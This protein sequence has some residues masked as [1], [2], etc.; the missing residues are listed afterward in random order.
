MVRWLSGLHCHLSGSCFPARSGP[1]CV[2]LAYSPCVS[3][4]CFGGPH[5]QKCVFIGKFSCQHLWPRHW[6]VLE[7]VPG[8]RTGAARCSSWMNYIQRMNFTTLYLV[9]LCV[10]LKNVPAFF[11]FYQIEK[12]KARVSLK[13]YLLRV[14]LKKDLKKPPTPTWSIVK[15]ET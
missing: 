11:L 10:T 13:I 9:W 3:F 4:G 7:L 15:T 8:Q 2:E 12:I 1:F 5:H 14:H 6:L